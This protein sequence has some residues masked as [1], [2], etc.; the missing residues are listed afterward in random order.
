MFN[1]YHK[2]NNNF[3]NTLVKLSRK[4]FFYKIVGLKDTFESRVVLIFFHLSIILLINKTKFKEKDAMQKLFDNVF[5][6]MEYDLREQGLGDVAVN[7]KMKILNKIF[8][9]ILLKINNSKDIKFDVNTNLFEKHIN[10]FNS[11]DININKLKDYFNSFYDICLEL[12]VKDIIK[13]NI[14]K[15]INNGC[16]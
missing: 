8:Y 1:F 3:Y 10:K 15:E 5:F 14:E 11:K 4:I 7:K 6:N 13:G 12:D 9:D 2:N 16:T